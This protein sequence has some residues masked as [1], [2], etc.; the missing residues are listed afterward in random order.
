MDGIALC[1]GSRAD[2]RA[3]RRAARA[4]QSRTQS[5]SESICRREEA[6]DRSLPG[7]PLRA[8]RTIASLCFLRSCRFVPDSARVV[9]KIRGFRAVSP[10][11]RYDDGISSERVGGS[12]HA[13]HLSKSALDRVALN[14]GS[15]VSWNDDSDSRL[16]GCLPGEPDLEELASNPLS[17][18]T[19]SVDIG[20]ARQPRGAR[21]PKAVRRRRTSTEAS[22]SGAGDP[23]CGDDSGLP[24]PTWWTCEY[25]NRACEHGVCCAD[26]T[27]AFPSLLLTVQK[28]VLIEGRKPIQHIEIYQA[29]RA[30]PGCTSVDLST[31]CP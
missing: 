14:R 17:L 16:P 21:E 18:C 23:S 20:T 15:V 8:E 29:C 30:L 6:G 13:D 4:L 11:P 9:A 2:Y 7:I 10:R 26:G 5:M 25:E 28:S 31:L 22:R 27:S 19:N 12:H 24:A 3:T 1:D